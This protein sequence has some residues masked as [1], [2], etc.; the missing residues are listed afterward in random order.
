MTDGRGHEIQDSVWRT[1]QDT[2]SKRTWHCLF[3]F[4]GRAVGAGLWPEDIL[5]QELTGTS[6]F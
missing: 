6:Q 5:S 3:Y 1:E 2:M 4:V